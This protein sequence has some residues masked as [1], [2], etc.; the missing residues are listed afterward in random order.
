M[1]RMDRRNGKD[2]G[3]AKAGPHEYQSKDVGAGFSRPGVAGR[4]VSAE[5]ERPVEAGRS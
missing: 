4:R 5:R 3:P 1:T 2:D